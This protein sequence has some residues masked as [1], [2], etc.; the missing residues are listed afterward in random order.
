MNIGENRI[1]VTEASINDLINE[2]RKRGVNVSRQY[3]N[4]DFNGHGYV[5]LG[6]PSGTLWAT[7]NVGAETETGY[8][9]YFAWG[10]TK[11]FEPGKRIFD[12]RNYK[13][14]LVNGYLADYNFDDGWTVLHKEDDA[15]RMNMGGDWRMPTREQLLELIDGDNTTHET[16][17]VKRVKGMLFTSRRNGNTLFVPFGGGYCISSVSDV[18]SGG[19]LWSS[20]LDGKGVCSAFG[21]EI[22]GNGNANLCNRSRSFGFSVRGVING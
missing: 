17:M 8:G 20:S 22:D 15:A 6:L 10:E 13:F 4:F 16:V 18:G 7:C 2:L 14:V 5:D 19:V 11:G 12:W 3:D 1:L 9:L 21:L